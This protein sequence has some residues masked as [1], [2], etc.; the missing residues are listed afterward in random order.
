MV[1]R[2][3][4]STYKSF[5][6]FFDNRLKM[7]LEC[8]QVVKKA[9][10]L[11]GC[12]KASAASQLKEVNIPPHGIASP[13]VLFAVLGLTKRILVNLN[14]SRGGQKAYKM[15]EGM[16]YRELLSTLGLSSSEKRLTGK[17]IVLYSFLR[18]GNGEGGA[19][20]FSLVTDDTIC[21]NSTKLLHG[22][23][24]LDTRKSYSP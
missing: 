10:C 14:A 6:H 4:K 23:L 20:L 15:L 22:R 24:G 7:S 17:L 13:R 2:F 11:L 16:S 21:G 1:Q 19:S 5:L 12:I 9:N 18:R 8:T 3:G